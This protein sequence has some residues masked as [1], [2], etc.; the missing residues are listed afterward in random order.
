M[1]NE[2]KLHRDKPSDSTRK[3]TPDE[4]P[5]ARQATDSKRRRFRMS[6]KFRSRLLATGIPDVLP[7]TCGDARGEL[8]VKKIGS[9]SRSP[10]VCS[11][12]VWLTPN[13]FENE[14]G[15]CFTKCWKRTIQHGRTPLN[16]YIKLGLIKLHRQYCN[17][18]LCSSPIVDTGRNS[19]TKVIGRFFIFF[20]VCLIDVLFVC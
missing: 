18:E 11:D 20:R 15:H 6:K 17:C 1:S 3:E 2:R 8:H 16:T 13:Q 4:L 5:T 9:G 10:C 19:I 14:G 12:G 7:V